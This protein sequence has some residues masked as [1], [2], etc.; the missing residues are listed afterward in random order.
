VVW[1]LALGVLALA[2][3]SKDEEGSTAPQPLTPVISALEPD[4]GAVGDTVAV[5]GRDFG[6]TQGSSTVLFSAVQAPV[7][8]WSDTLLRARVPRGAVTGPVIVV[9]GGRTSNPVTFTVYEG[10]TPVP[11]FLLAD[12]NPNSATHGEQISP[13][14]YVG[15]VSAWYFGKAT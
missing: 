15:G 5:H 10:A 2:G 14:R 4:S 11:D 1:I 3:C 13:R 9:V 12:V 6:Q 8:S 7:L